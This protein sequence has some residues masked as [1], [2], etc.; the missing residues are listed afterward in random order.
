M[1]F[2]GIKDNVIFDLHNDFPTAIDFGE[3]NGYVDECKDVAL[4][5]AVW[6]TEL[7]SN[8]V[9]FVLSSVER[10]KAVHGNVYS[11]VEDLGFLCGRD[12]TAF[13]FNKFVYCSLTWNRANRFAGGALEDGVLTSDGERLIKYMNG[14][15]AV[16][17]AHIGKSAFYAVLDAAQKPICSH[18]GFADHPRC[19]NDNMIRALTRR[20]AL[21]GLCAVKTFT[22]AETADRWAESVDRFVQSYGIDCLCVGTDFN[23][24]YDLPHDLC[25]YAHFEKVRYKLISLGY[26]ADDIDKIFYKNAK[27]F[28]E[29]IQNE[30]H[31]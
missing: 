4:T 3:Y 17:L 15:C 16:D 9:D 28:C 23:G 13:D 22:G 11:A 26:S 19:L 31:L 12:S 7:K 8:A 30:R 27:R 1:H 10:L 24:T 18:T 29:E 21:I 25:E 2:D 6:T 20:N 5:A 14:K